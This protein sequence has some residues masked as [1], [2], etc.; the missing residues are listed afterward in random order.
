MRFLEK[1]KEKK[2]TLAFSCPKNDYDIAKVAWEN[3]ADAI[4]VHLNVHHH[5]SKTKFLSY[6]EER[7]IL[8][9]IISDSPVPVGVV[10]GGNIEAVKNDWTDI[11]KAGFDFLSLYLH[12]AP[13]SILYQKTLTRM[14]A[15]S[16]DYTFSEIE[17]F[18]N[19]GIEVLE[20]SIVHPDK[21]GE[22]LTGR[23]LIK[24]KK[25]KEISGLP[26]VVPTQK[27]VDVD[28]LQGLSDV[29]VNGLLLGAMVTGKDIDSIQTTVAKFRKGIDSL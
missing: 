9:K 11:E 10:L 25:I 26:I 27:K 20:S 5:A 7:D 2:M 19:L 12:H 4:K 6:K 3:G 23:D 22:L 21:Y 24:Y 1:V 16:Y 18:K 8:E 15:A 28:D 14:L 13:S 17:C 29:G